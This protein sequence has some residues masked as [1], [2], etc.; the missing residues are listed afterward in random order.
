MKRWVAFAFEDYYPGGGMGDYVGT[1]ATREEAQRAAEAQG[2]DNA[3]VA[4][5]S[6]DGTLVDADEADEP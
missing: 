3:D 4:Y 6:D 1:F 5:I 2:Y